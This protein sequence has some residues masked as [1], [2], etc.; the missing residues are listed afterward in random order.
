MI[1]PFQTPVKGMWHAKLERFGQL[2]ESFLSFFSRAKVIW[3]CTHSLCQSGESLSTTLSTFE[4]FG[5]YPDALRLNP[6]RL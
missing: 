5:C 6:M 2:P 1:L 4:T 3:Q